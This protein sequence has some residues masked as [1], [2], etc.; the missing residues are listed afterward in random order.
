MGLYHLKR[1]QTIKADLE[2]VWE[3]FSS[4]ANLA[5]ITPDYMNFTVTSEPEDHIYPGQ[6]ITYKVSPLLGIPLN[7]MTEITHV[8]HLKMFV[9]EQRKGPYKIWHHQH[10][11]TETEGGVLMKDI[12]HYELPMWIL[13]DFA[14]VLFIR[15]QLNDIFNYRKKVITELL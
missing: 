12:V 13:G 4:P 1:E 6:V 9:D 10:L 14:H 8:E 15:K 2:T 5:N 3:F 11:F 7:W